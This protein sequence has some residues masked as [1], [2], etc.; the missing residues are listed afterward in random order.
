MTGWIL[1]RAA[2]SSILRSVDGEPTGEPDRLFWAII[3]GAAD[4]SSGASNSPTKCSLPFGLSV[5]ITT[6]QFISTFTVEMIRS[7]EPAAF[8]ISLS[9]L[10]LSEW[11]APISFASS[12]F[13]SLVNAVTSQPHALANCNAKW[14]KPPIP[15]TATLEVGLMSYC[16]SGLNTVTPP[17][18]SGPTALKSSPSGILM[19]LVSFARTLSA[20]P[21]WL[22]MIVPSC[23][24]HRLWSPSMHRSQTLQYPLCQPSPTLSP[25]SRCLTCLP[26]LRTLPATSCPP[27]NGYWVIPHSFC[28]ID[29]SLWQM[30]QLC[31]SIST[32][33]SP[34]APGSYS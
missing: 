18:N 29:K 1:C 21:P 30:P 7:K 14:P 34:K 23:S 27:T 19:T 25:N 8:S 13:D 4:I 10:E 9:S 20:K 26:L 15:I 28:H 5:L 33:W 24:G 17:H 32:S 3:I 6:S 2:K 31:T 12:I 11:W 16:I 22:P